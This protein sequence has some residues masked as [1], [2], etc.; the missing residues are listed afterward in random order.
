MNLEKAA[1]IV[2]GIFLFVGVLL[3][4]AVIVTLHFWGFVGEAINALAN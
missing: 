1:A 3:P 2:A 4:S